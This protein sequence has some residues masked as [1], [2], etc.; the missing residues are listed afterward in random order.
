MLEV[1]YL[2]RLAL[3]APR[4][5]RCV[6]L[7]LSLVALT[8]VFVTHVIG[9]RR[10]SAV[11]KRRLSKPPRLELLN[12]IAEY[13]ISCAPAFASIEPEDA[14]A[15]RRCC[16]PDKPGRRRQALRAA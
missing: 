1:D 10:R 8:D 15:D 13:A 2:S 3:A 11:R 9:T 7:D 12:L 6:G 14:N 5:S 4:R 16:R